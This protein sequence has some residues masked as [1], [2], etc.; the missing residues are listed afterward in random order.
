MSMASAIK[1]VR[2]P[3]RLLSRFGRSGEGAVAVEFALVALPFFAMLFAILQTALVFFA[4]QVFQTAVADSA[5]LIMTGQGQSFTQAT[6]KDQVCSR[7]VAL[8]DCADGVSIDVQSTTDLGDATPAAVPVKDGKV[9]TTD[10]SFTDAPG[11]AIVTVRA[12]YAWPLVFSLVD[13]GLANLGT[14]HHLMVATAVFRNEPF[15]N[16]A[17]CAS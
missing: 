5:R 3:R 17:S 13:L 8:F 1:P 14:S 4:D 10:F 2:R 6:F 12:V 9:D 7:L 11:C 16:E 15:G